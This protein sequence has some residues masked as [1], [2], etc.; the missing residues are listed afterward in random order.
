MV[1]APPGQ[2]RGELL[3]VDH[4]PIGF[5]S[6]TSEYGLIGFAYQTDRHTNLIDTGL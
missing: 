6:L 4:G 5:A 3:A 1:R 2:E